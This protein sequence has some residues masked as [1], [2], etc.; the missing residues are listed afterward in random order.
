LILGS[1]SR[2]EIVIDADVERATRQHVS[3]N[4]F[5]AFGL[6]PVLG[7]LLDR[8]DDMEPRGRD[9]AV[10]S[11]DFWTRRFGRDPAVVGRTFRWGRTT[12]EI[13]GV[14]PQGFTGTEPGRITDFFAPATLNTQALNNPG[15]A[16]FRIWVRASDGTSPEQVRQL[17]Q[18]QVKRDGEEAFKLLA[19]DSPG[20][21]IAAFLNEQ[22]LLAPAGAGVS[23]LQ[24]TFRRPM[25]ILAAL[26]VLFLL[27]AC[28]NV[29]N[30]LIAQ[31]AARGR[32]MALRV[33]IGAARWRLI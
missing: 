18:S 30:L 4:V 31:A 13:V 23:G 19:P 11:Y 27:I 21:R 6:Q 3:G 25:F 10:I 17:L 14:S 26:V 15:W 22:I 9:V 7:R 8:S 28:S 29:A 2:Q 32:E 20:P 16:W 33:S 5:S 12:I 1:V 24:R